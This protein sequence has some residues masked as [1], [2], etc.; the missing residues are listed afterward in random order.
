MFSGRY[1]GRRYFAARYFGMG[2]DP[3][4]GSG[5]FGGHLGMYFDDEEEI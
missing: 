3:T 4:P 2:A 1:F 5:G